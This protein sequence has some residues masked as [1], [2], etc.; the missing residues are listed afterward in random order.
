ML[1]HAPHIKNT[2]DQARARDESDSADSSLVTPAAKR[3]KNAL[4]VADAMDSTPPPV[5][6]QQTVSKPVY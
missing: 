5:V 4:L 2:S 1:M 3:P 6:G